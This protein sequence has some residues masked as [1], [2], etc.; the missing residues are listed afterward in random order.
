MRSCS[1]PTPPSTPRA[2]GAS[3]PPPS[4]A[5]ASG[6]RGAA[7]AGGGGGAPGAAGVAGVRRLVRDGVIRPGETAVAVLTGHVLKD[8]GILLDVHRAGGPEGTAARPW[9]NAPVEIDATADALA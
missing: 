2:W 8:P 7:P 6:G 4:A 3:P 5:K 1:R 9:A